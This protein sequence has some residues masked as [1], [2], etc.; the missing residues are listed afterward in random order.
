MCEVFWEECMLSFIVR[1]IVC[2]IIVGIMNKN[3]FR[4]T[5]TPAFK[6]DLI[7][8]VGLLLLSYVIF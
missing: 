3:A 7:F 6:K 4:G 2:F 8:V 1:V 5:Y